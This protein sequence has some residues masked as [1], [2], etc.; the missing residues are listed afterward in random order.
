M[1]CARDAGAHNHKEKEAKVSMSALTRRE[2]LNRST[3]AAGTAAFTFP[4][5]GR[6]LGANDQIGV[7]CIGVGG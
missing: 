6:V 1:G 5:V 4:F 2:F 3:L 7:G